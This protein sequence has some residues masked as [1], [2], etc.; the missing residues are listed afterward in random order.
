MLFTFAFA[1]LIVYLTLAA[2]FESFVHPAVI[3]LT[4]PLAV[5]GGAFGLFML[6]GTLNIYSQ[7]GFVIL[8]ALATKNGILIVEFANQLRDE[9]HDIRSA[10]LEASQ[11][12]LRPILMTSIATMAG[13]LP[14]V[15][16]HGAGSESRVAI[17]VVIVFGVGIATMFTLLVVPVAYDFAARFT[18][19]PERIKRE[20]ESYERA[21]EERR[22]AE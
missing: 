16:A 18:K 9:G 15:L 3:M 22:A 2:Q 13:A 11:M 5:A 8:I 21:E 4:A 6:D 17:G 10:V 7:I 14:L 19:S 12:R 1:L 20:I